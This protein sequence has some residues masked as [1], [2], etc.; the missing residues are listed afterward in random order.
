MTWKQRALP[1]R[2][3]RN[4]EGS[5]CPQLRHF[6]CLCKNENIE[7]AYNLVSFGR[8][9]VFKSNNARCV[10]SFYA[11]FDFRT[12]SG[13]SRPRKISFSMQIGSLTSSCK[14]Q[15][16]DQPFL[17][18][19]DRGFPNRRQPLLPS[20]RR[21]SAVFLF[22]F[23]FGKKVLPHPRKMYCM[24]AHRLCCF[25]QQ[26]IVL[27]RTNA[28]NPLICLPFKLCMNKA[29]THFARFGQGKSL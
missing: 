21:F 16:N 10:F 17:F 19:F 27:S 5:L 13:R 1:H 20:Q 28:V 11:L 14:A 25:S 9:N 4:E 24:V 6:A 18:V 26:F 2:P 29:N 22:E 8:S 23:R 3:H 15:S 12:R 7:R